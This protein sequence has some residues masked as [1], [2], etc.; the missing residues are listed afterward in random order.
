[1]NKLKVIQEYLIDKKAFTQND[2]VRLKPQMAQAAQ[3][4]YDYWDEDYAEMLGGGGICQD[5]AEN[6]AEVLNNH[7]IEAG[8]VS[9]SVG[10][11]H[12]FT[13]VQ[14]EEGIFT[15]DINP[16]LYER[17]GGY[18]WEKIPGVKFSPNDIYI[19]MIN[20]DPSKFREIIEEY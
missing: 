18:N 13:V 15:I 17:G 20:D 16:H 6:M 1:M 7:G 19:D 5:I 4:A 2:I 11:Q 9:A 12:V 8:T 14:V 10:D 3:K